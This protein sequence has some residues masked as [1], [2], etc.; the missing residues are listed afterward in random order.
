MSV[1]IYGDL[2][3][4]LRDLIVKIQIMERKQLAERNRSDS[5]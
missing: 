1:E 5:K 3:T 2:K 4:E